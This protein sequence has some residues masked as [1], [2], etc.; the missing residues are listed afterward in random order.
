MA[1]NGD[2]ATTRGNMVRFNKVSGEWQVLYRP[3][4]PNGG[5]MRAMGFDRREDAVK[6]LW[7]MEA[8]GIA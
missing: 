6:V 4:F 8:D 2:Y 5:P 3:N 7:K 1:T